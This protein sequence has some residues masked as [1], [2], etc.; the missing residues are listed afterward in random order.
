MLWVLCQADPLICST[1][2]EEVPGGRGGDVGGWAA[3]SQGSGS[4]ESLA[5][6]GFSPQPP[7]VEAAQGQHLSSRQTHGYP[8]WPIEQLAQV[9][10]PFLSSALLAGSGSLLREHG[11]PSWP[12]S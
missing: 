9:F 2:Q 8:P 6:A 10:N 12:T 3:S 4:Q 7:A 5:P 1:V 11:C